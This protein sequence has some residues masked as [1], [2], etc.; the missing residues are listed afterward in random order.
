VQLIN[1]IKNIT[2][3]LVDPKIVAVDDRWS[4]FI[5]HLHIKKPNMGPQNSGHYYQVV[6]MR[7][8][9]LIVCKIKKLIKIAEDDHKA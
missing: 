4:L 3:K 5:D 7:N 9:G 8:S 6:A 2:I 1:I